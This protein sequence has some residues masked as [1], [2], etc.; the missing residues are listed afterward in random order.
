MPDPTIPPIVCDMTTA[1]DTPEERLV[2][3]RTLFADHLAIRERTAR[4]IRFRLQD[5]P[6]VADHVRDLAAREKACCAFFDFTV[7]EADGQV[8]WDATV[9]DDPVARQILDEFYVLP[10]TASLGEESLYDRFEARGLEIVRGDLDA[11]A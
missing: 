4:G 11:T 5:A 9:V 2:E 3:Y 8:V 1:V 6:G 10:E 7:T